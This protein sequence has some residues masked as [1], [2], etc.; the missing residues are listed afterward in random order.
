M[1]RKSTYRGIAPARRR[2]NGVDLRFDWP[3]RP[4]LGP[5]VG[6]MEIEIRRAT[7]SDR[8]AILQIFHEVVAGEDTYTI[9]PQITAKMRSHIGSGRE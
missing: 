7:E 8:E 2:R 9:D 4:F 3:N 6:P 5:K 1:V